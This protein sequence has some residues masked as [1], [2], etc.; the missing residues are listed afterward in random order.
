MLAATCLVT[1]LVCADPP[2][3]TPE[4]S[5]FVEAAQR[6]KRRLSSEPL[7]WSMQLDTGAEALM[8]VSIHKSPT[9]SLYEFNLTVDAKTQPVG[10]ILCLG[11]TW[12]VSDAFVKGR[13]RQYEAPI[14]IPAGMYLMQSSEL[15]LVDAEFLAGSKVDSTDG[16]R[17]TIRVPLT[18]AHR[19]Q[20][21]TVLKKSSEL[22]SVLKGS[23]RTV[24]EQTQRIVTDAQDVIDKGNRFVIDSR[25]GQIL[26]MG[27]PARRIRFTPLVWLGPGPQPKL[28]PPPGDFPDHTAPIPE[29]DLGDVI[30]IS[31]NKTWKPGQ[32]SGELEL[33]LLNLRTREIRRAPFPFGPALPGCFS[34]DRSLIYA[35][36]LD[37]EVGAIRPVAINLKTGESQWIGGEAFTHGNWLDPIVSPKGDRLAILSPMSGQGLNSQIHVIDLA[38]GK[39]TPV[40]KPMDAAMLNWHPDGKSLFCMVREPGTGG[41]TI[42]YVCRLDLD[43]KVTKLTKGGFPEV[44]PVQKRILFESED[45]ERVL[46]SCDLN[47]KD[48]RLFGDGFKGYGFPTASPDG[49]LILM[50]FK[51]GEAPQPCLVNLENY[52]VTPLDLGPGLWSRP[53]W[54]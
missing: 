51:K 11:E 20:I 50:K 3:L 33:M 40:G 14:S 54:R 36:G 8:G 6:T 5:K 35:T 7:K 39:P 25:T 23:N 53:K 10:T 16:D 18:D 46:K 12:Y 2:K 47:G 49:M 21:E 31:S 26:E 9:A 44:L 37:P 42:R 17:V 45:E 13:Y 24:P 19:T 28:Q 52:E 22:K 30:Q 32:P 4:L 41:S 38:S 15:R 27:M 29:G 43:G 48:I 1:L 34:P